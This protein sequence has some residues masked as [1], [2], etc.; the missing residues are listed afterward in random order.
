MVVRYVEAPH[1]ADQ[2]GDSF[3]WP[4]VFLGGGITGVDDWQASA[5]GM[6]EASGVD[7]TVYN[8]RRAN[9]DVTDPAAHEQQVRWEYRHLHIAD[10]V[11]FWFPACDPAVTVQPIALAELYAAMERRHQYRLIGAAPGYPRRRDIA[12]QLRSAQTA[13]HVPNSVVLQSSLRHTV[14]LVVEVIRSHPYQTPRA[15]FP[16]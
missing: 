15:E 6:L 4:A 5:V 10:I 8:P 3:R 2:R 12:L 14:N 9:F 11:M 16:G 1:Q 7:V 13:N